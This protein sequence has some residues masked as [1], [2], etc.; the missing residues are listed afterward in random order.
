MP[1]HRTLNLV[2]FQSQVH[3]FVGWFQRNR[4]PALAVT[5]V[6]SLWQNWLWQCVCQSSRLVDTNTV[7]VILTD[8]NK[9]GMHLSG[10]VFGIQIQRHWVWS[11]GRAGWGI[12]SFFCLS[13][14]TL[15]QTCLC[16]IPPP[17]HP[18]PKFV[19]T[20]KIPYPSVL[21]GLRVGLTVGGMVTQKYCIC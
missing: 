9:R 17:H 12:V 1:N 7:H 4:I 10:R 14:S 21:K 3:V 11:P 8:R 20:L 16:L 5:A 13:G 2:S 15:A 18:P 6:M 19:C